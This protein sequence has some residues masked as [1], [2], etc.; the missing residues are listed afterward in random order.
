MHVV[1]LHKAHKYTQFR[2][3][4]GQRF[5]CCGFNAT[6]RTQVR[7]HPKPTSLKS[8]VQ[9]YV[10]IVVPCMLLGFLRDFDVCS[11]DVQ[12]WLNVSGFGVGLGESGLR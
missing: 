5:S 6:K 10:E 8:T 4:L 12:G 2:H 11:A 9:N 7:K 1:L 3:R